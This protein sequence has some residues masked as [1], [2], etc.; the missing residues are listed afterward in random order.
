M[1]TECT[2]SFTA[3]QSAASASSI[4]NRALTTL[5]SINAL[6]TQEFILSLTSTHPSQ[7]IDTYTMQTMPGSEVWLYVTYDPAASTST[8]NS[9]VE[10]SL[11]IATKSIT[12]LLR[13]GQ[14]LLVN[15]ISKLSDIVFTLNSSSTDPAPIHAVLMYV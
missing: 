4:N 6:A 9:I 14:S 15:D 3:A 10:I 8:K 11:T 12:F 13:P 7:T 1:S 2:L 5:S